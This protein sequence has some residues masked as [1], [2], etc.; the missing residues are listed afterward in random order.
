MS[1]HQ[2]TGAVRPNSGLLG[3]VNE[4]ALLCPV[5]VYAAKQLH[6]SIL[7]THRELCADPGRL[8]YTQMKHNKFL[9]S[10]CMCLFFIQ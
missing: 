1:S 9:V 3:S 7:Q 2:P 8:A 5:S 10:Y 6:V 4:S